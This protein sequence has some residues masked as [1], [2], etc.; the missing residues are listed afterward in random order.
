[1]VIRH[2]SNG[3]HLD[4]VEVAEH[5]EGLLTADHAAAVSAHLARCA[6]CQSMAASVATVTAHL[7]AEPRELPIPAGVA[8]RIDAALADEAAARAAA[9][10]PAARRQRR[11]GFAERYLR[12]LRERMPAIATAAASI[13]VLGLIGYTVANEGVRDGGDD[14]SAE[15]ADSADDSGAADEPAT[16]PLDAPAEEAEEEAD[17]ESA[18]T[19]LDS[20]EPE[21]GE[22]GS[23]ASDESAERYSMT[24]PQ[25]DALTAELQDIVAG[26]AAQ[27]QAGSDGEA[28][29]TALA[30]SLGQ[31]LIGST[32]TDLVEAGS[33][34]VAIDAGDPNTVDGWLLPDCGAAEEQALLMFTAPRQ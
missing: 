17:E 34:L 23:A 7:A 6:V 32:D 14:A 31:E 19:D 13:A 3:G 22:D 21:A 29:G 25:R 4:P 33:I 26:R 9:A 20:A 30:E 2:D 8:A 16:A 24:A 28:C 12:P 11:P 27:A 15:S 10:A 1:M 18:D 5:A